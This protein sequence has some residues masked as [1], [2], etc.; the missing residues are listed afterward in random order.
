LVRSR[1]THRINPPHNVR[2]LVNFLT[3]VG[4]IH[5]F[6]NDLSVDNLVML[7]DFERVTDLSKNMMI[8][9]LL[10]GKQVILGVNTFAS[11]SSLSFR[12]SVIVKEP[13][14]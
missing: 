10:S 7:S 6:S 12:L 13:M 14:I 8:R 3:N 9:P 2:F 4:S 1:E 5:R 11:G